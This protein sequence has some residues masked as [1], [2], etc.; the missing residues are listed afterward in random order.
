MLACRVVVRDVRGVPELLVPGH[1]GLGAELR[2]R[3][4]LG[5]TGQERRR[6]ELSEVTGA[7]IVTPA[8]LDKRSGADLPVRAPDVV[9]AGGVRRAGVKQGAA[10]HVD[11]VL[12][13]Q[14]RL[15]AA[16]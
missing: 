13:R 11:L 14:P 6:D 5:E 2:Q 10:E 8:E 9:P 16:Q 12:E 1:E 7:D 3:S 4:R 15:P